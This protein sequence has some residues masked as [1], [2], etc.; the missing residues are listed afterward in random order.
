MPQ[1]AGIPFFYV[2][3]NPF[4]DIIVH[5]E[6][7]HQ[8]GLEGWVYVDTPDPDAE[9]PRVV[10]DPRL[11]TRERHLSDRSGNVQDQDVLSSDFFLP[12]GGPA[13]EDK[14]NGR[15]VDIIDLR[16]KAVDEVIRQD[17]AP[18]ADDDE[19]RRG[20]EAFIGETER[21][22]SSP[23]ANVIEAEEKGV[24]EE[25]GGG[26]EGGSDSQGAKKVK[27]D[28]KEDP[29]IR[30]RENFKPD[31]S[32]FDFNRPIGGDDKL[33][34]SKNLFVLGR[35]PDGRLRNSEVRKWFANL[36]LNEEN[37]SFFGTINSSGPPFLV[38][39]KVLP[40]GRLRDESLGGVDA[41]EEQPREE[42]VTSELPAADDEEV[43]TLPP[44]TTEAVEENPT[45]T[46]AVLET[47]D[48][49]DLIE[50]QVDESGEEAPDFPI[51]SRSPEDDQEAEQRRP[52]VL[53]ESREPTDENDIRFEPSRLE[54]ADDDLKN[55]IGDAKQKPWVD[56]Q[57][58]AT[59]FT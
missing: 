54:D 15:L 47:T 45:T 20:K 8:R 43:S 12:V 6:A 23:N 5:H 3:G 31:E 22:R 53:A 32:F 2:E 27:A 37:R 29:L 52:R 41:P 26:A 11:P 51:Q 56:S 18:P 16:K 19:A 7:I 28:T 10:V 42:R 25:E 49:F 57:R 9:Q 36:D 1:S 17:F 59:D 30:I 14:D 4:K 50:E 39:F 58:D 13:A 46:S 21:D 48:A 35:S 33:P 40:F 24:V 34:T 38:N 44:E 55:L